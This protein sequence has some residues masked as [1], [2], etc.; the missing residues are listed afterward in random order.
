MVDVV[1]PSSLVVETGAGKHLISH[2]AG[3]SAAAARTA[4]YVIGRGI[5]VYSWAWNGHSLVHVNG[6]R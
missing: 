4:V 1:F 6:M 3:H 5:R 2:H